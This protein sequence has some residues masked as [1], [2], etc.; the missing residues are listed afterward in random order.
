LPLNHDYGSL[1]KPTASR[2][3]SGMSTLPRWSSV[4]LVLVTQIVV[5]NPTGPPFYRFKSRNFH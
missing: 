2:T 3:S 5:Q 1:I 4:L